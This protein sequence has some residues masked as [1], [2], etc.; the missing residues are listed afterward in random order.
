MVLTPEMLQQAVENWKSHERALTMDYNH[1]SRLGKTAEEQKSA[2]WLKGLEY[3]PYS[4]KKGGILWAIFE[5]TDAAVG[6]VANKEYQYLSIEF[7]ADY[8]HPEDKNFIGMYLLAI[9]LTNR[10]FI[11][12]TAPVALMSEG[13]AKILADYGKGGQ[14]TM[15]VKDGSKLSEVVKQIEDMGH[16]VVGWYRDMAMMAE[17]KIKD[18]PNKVAPNKTDSTVTTTELPRFSFDM[19]G[20]VGSLTFKE[21]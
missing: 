3:E 18:K 8:F 21:A 12:G 15:K 20:P 11:E 17:P 2:G 13:V 1:G 4:D 16:E 9:A 5:P 14:I 19:N 6:Y 10:P 7:E